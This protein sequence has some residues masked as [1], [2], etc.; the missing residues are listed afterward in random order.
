[1]ST[2]DIQLIPGGD[3]WGRLREASLAADE[4]GFAT[5][6]VCDHLAGYSMSSE[7]MH[8]AFSLRRLP[9][10]SSVWLALLP[11]SFPDDDGPR[12]NS[13]C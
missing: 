4:G 3:D 10:A 6:W 7:T 12:K 8:E 1:M 9:W 5:L 2:I 11:S 13:S